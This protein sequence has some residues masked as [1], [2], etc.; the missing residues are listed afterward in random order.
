MPPTTRPTPP[1]QFF[2]E[3]MTRSLHTLLSLFLTVA[4]CTTATAGTAL[5]TPKKKPAATRTTP[6]KPAKKKAAKKKAAPKKGGAKGKKKAAN[7]QYSTDE[8]RGLESKRSS[9]RKE[10]KKNEAALKANRADVSRRL[11]DLM[12]IN[13]E[14]DRHKQ[15]IQGIQQDITLIDNDISLINA[16]LATLQ[17]QLEK[18]KQNYVRSLRY[19]SRKHSMQDKLLFVFSADNFAQMYRRLRMVKEYASWQK[20]QGELLKKKQAQVQQKQAQLQQAI[21]TKR[22]MLH[23]GEAEKKALEGKQAEQQ[24]MV[25]QLQ[26]E[27]KTIQNML[28]Q[29]RRD[30]DRLNAEIDRLIAIEVEKARQRALEEQRKKAAAEAERKRREAELARKRAAA[31]AERRENERRLKEARDREQRAKN[32]ARAALEQQMKDATREAGLYTAAAEQK[33]R[34]AEA[35]REALE[36][37]IKAD[38]RRSERDLAAAKRAADESRSMSSADRMM[39]GGFEA[40]RGRLPMPV[41]GSCKIVSHYGRNAVEGLRGV[42]VE[43]RGIDI[44]GQPGCQARAIYDGEVSA[45]YNY[46][47]AYVVMI[48]HGAYISVYCNLRGV[49]VSSGQKVS[50]RQAVG[51]VAA[52]GILQFQLRKMQQRLNPEHWLAR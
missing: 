49:S 39:S 32:A 18:R 4:L 7:G 8:I 11:G 2:H 30:E 26:K 51:T 28:L 47:G 44:K 17:Q 10:I 27:Q 40:N 34:E 3:D 43:N 24:S 13:G 50:T 41:T 12:A 46:G 52:N 21:G 31:E 16:Q 33:A 5:Q 19:I 22:T 29:H 1:R 35:E 37:K 23:K 20:A 42:T 36:R 9:L 6:A 25:Q 48:R 15:N 45:V 38:E 14:I